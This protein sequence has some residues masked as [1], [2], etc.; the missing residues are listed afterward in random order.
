MDEAVAEQFINGLNPD[1][2]TLVNTGRPNAFSEALNRAKGAEAGLIRQRGASYSVSGQRPTPPSVVQ[3]P[4]PP[5]RYDSGSGSGKK[6][7]LK[8]LLLTRKDD[9]SIALEEL[10]GDYDQEGEIYPSS[11]TQCGISDFSMQ[12][13]IE[14][15]TEKSFVDILESKLEVGTI[16]NSIEDAYLLYCQYAHDKGFSVRKGDQRCFA[17]TNEIQSKEFICSCEGLKDERSSSKRIP[18]YQKP[19]IRT[20]CKAKLKISREKGGEWRVIRFFQDHNHEMFA[21]DQTHLL[22][23]A[24]NISHAKKCTLEAMVNAEIC[25]S[26]AVYFMENEASGPENLG[27]NRKDSYDH[28]SRM[29]KHTK[30]ENGDATSLIQYFIN[31]ANK[32]NYFYWN[33]QLDDDDRVMNF[34]FRDYRCSIDYEY[35]GDVLSIDT[36]YR[37]NKYYLICAPFVGINHR[38]QNVMFG[39]AFM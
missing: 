36:T 17:R 35:F 4:P 24:R 13:N 18:V 14:V 33:M 20:Q 11:K 29:K 10:E 23:S 22:R 31:K 5:P 8:L 38:M 9:N 2:F 3:F 32:E 6:E 25:V 34:F 28:M 12:E 15:Q 16:V 1:I 21:P 30:V 37:T 39:L 27:F 26:N 19:V 7:F